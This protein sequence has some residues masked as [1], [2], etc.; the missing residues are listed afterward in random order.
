MGRNKGIPGLSF[1]W[2]RATGLSPAKSKV[3]RQ[4]G[5]PLTRAGQQRKLGKAMGCCVPAAL[6][7]TGSITVA[8]STCDAILPHQS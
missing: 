4:T 3:S 1:S 7:L 6:L 5:I 8:S 2:R